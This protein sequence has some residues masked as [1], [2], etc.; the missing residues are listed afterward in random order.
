M[1]KKYK[2]VI[3]AYRMMLEI[4]NLS[5][6]Y[7]TN[8]N[9]LQNINVRVS[10]GEVL[11]IIGLNGSGKST[12]GKAVMNMIPYRQGKIS[13]NGK[14]IT[15]L[16]PYELSR[17]GISIMLQGGR[18]FNDLSVRDNLQLALGSRSAPD[19]ILEICSYIP[20]FSESYREKKSRMADQLSGGQR[21]QLALAMAIALH[22][23]LLILDEPSAGLSPV[24]VDDMYRI[25]A[26][27]RQRMEISILLIEQN[28]N[29]AV[30]FSDRC[31]LLQQGRI[32]H[33]FINKDIKEVEFLMFKK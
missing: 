4:D 17:C 25:L 22:P 24:A 23:Q 21:Q 16:L 3:W 20:L 31:L 9:I 19:Y 26:D 27:I 12:L 14:S 18:V 32:A 11:G 10:R 2:A 7:V 13:F 30:T 29:K 28:I 5:G 33:T 8:V 6:G 1:I 15:G